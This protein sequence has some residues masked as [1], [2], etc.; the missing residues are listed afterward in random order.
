MT[1][2]VT[3]VSSQ[4]PHTIDLTRFHQV[5]GRLDV[6]SDIYIEQ[7]KEQGRGQAKWPGN[8]YFAVVY[9]GWLIHIDFYFPFPVRLKEL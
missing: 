3:R 6:L 2:S 4:L 5:E 8:Q 1:V 9:Y 7:G